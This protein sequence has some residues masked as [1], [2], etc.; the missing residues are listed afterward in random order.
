MCGYFQVIYG[1]DVW[2]RSICLL[3]H[4]CLPPLNQNPAPVEDLADFANFG[5]TGN[6][7]PPA[8]SAQVSAIQVSVLHCK[9]LQNLLERWFID[10]MTLY[11]LV[12]GNDT[13]D[14]ADFASFGV[15]TVSPPNV[16]RQFFFLTVYPCAYFSCSYLKGP[17]MT[18]LISQTLEP[19]HLSLVL[20]LQ[21]R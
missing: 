16:G 8:A 1:Y 14:F 9:R 13:L 2:R 3:S 21:P 11:A 4:L 17:P 20:A 12:Q 10:L 19:L 15:S 6:A 5:T 7:A 18:S